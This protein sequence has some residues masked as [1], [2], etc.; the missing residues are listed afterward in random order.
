MKDKINDLQNTLEFRDM[1]V[2]HLKELKMPQDAVQVYMSRQIE[3]E[4][5][6][7]EK[8]ENTHK[9]D[10]E[11]LH[12]RDISTQNLEKSK[13]TKNLRMDTRTIIGTNGYA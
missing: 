13:S 6:L 2:S 8:F 12:Q 11:S 4:R 1:F 10:Q 5:R 9:I 3:L 7:T